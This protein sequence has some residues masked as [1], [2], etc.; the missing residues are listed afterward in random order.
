MAEAPS[1]GKPIVLYDVLSSGAKAYL[2]V[3]NELISRSAKVE[4]SVPVGVS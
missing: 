3:A 2:A 4:S 1:F